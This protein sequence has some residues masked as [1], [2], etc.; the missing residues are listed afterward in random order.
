MVALEGI[1]NILRVGAK[2]AHGGLNK[3]AEMVE[4]CHGLDYLDDLQRH[5]NE[6]VYKKAHSILKK[7]FDVESSGDTMASAPQATSNEFV[8]QTA[9]T[10]NPFQF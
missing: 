3:L 10:A 7:Y 9:T 8:L 2:D 4:E 5:E 6:E 1:E